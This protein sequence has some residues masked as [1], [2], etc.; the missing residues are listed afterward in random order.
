[1]SEQVETA[2]STDPIGERV[3]RDNLRGSG[4]E[5][6]KRILFLGFLILVMLIPLGMVEG[7]VQERFARKLDVIA[8][9]GEQWG[10]PQEISA[11]ILIIPY[12]TEETQ[13]RSDG[14][15]GAVTIRR[16]A[17]FLPATS[18]VILQAAVEKRYRS[19][20]EVPVY[21]ADVAIAA[22]FDAPDFSPWDVEPGQIRWREAS[23]AIPLPGARAL[24]QISL[25]L[26]GAEQEI[27]AGLLPHQPGGKGLRA[28]LALDG[29]KAL[30]IDL[31]IA[32]NG[33]DNIHVL[34]LGGQS[35]IEVRSAWPHPSF[36]GARLPA[37]REISPEG[38]T[39]KYSVNHLASGIPL[40][41]RNGDF[42]L[43]A[44]ALD[45]IGISLVEPGDVHQ[46]TERI[47]KYGL[48]IVA[49]TFG[50]I[51][52]VGLMKHDRVHLVQYLLIGAALALFY[53]L[54]LSL[55]EQMPF[56]RAYAIASAIDIAIVGL[57]AG[58][59]IRRVLGLVTGL[60]LAALH[61]YMFTLLQ[62]ENYALLAGTL[63]LFV[64]LVAVMVL[65]R[66]I[67]WYAIGNAPEARPQK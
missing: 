25:K 58:I 40:A 15:T 6:A 45:M 51:F 38:F 26:N 59:T 33:R 9:L 22:Y 65:T 3:W 47:V 44:T 18:K 46:Q 49:L 23:L 14:T 53:L 35:E 54:L 10:P 16:Y 42:T 30:N 36:L 64:L 43:Q 12:D 63:G 61:A 37:T 57:Y 11:P 20:Y 13:L 24:R 1:M 19:I 4:F 34:P 66:R 67:D 8:E 62:M 21:A 56:S 32:L 28:D 5:A 7:V 48:L 60:L 29:P 55:A 27:E 17:N 31:A 52:I 2:G 41:W 39:A 50:T